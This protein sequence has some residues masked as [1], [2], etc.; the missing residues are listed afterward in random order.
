M[1]IFKN[2]LNLLRL[3]S[4]VGLLFISCGVLGDYSSFLPDLGDSDRSVISP[5]E[6]D[7]LGQKIIQDIYAQGEIL[8]DYD[9]NAYL[10]DL[11]GEIVSYSPMAGASFRF[12]IIKDKKIN[13]FALPG[14]YICIF[15]GLIYTTRTEAE[16]VSVISH[17]ISHIVLHHIF[18]GITVYNR[19]QWVAIAGILAGGLLA[20]INPA[21]AMIAINGVS[22]MAIENILSFS[23]DF[24]READRLGQK[25]M[26]KAG[27]DSRAMPVFFQRMQEQNKFNDNEAYAFLRS[28][29]VTSERI[30]E[31]QI[32]ANQLQTKMRPD[33][34]RFLLIREK[35][36]VRQIG[37]LAAIEFYKQAI[38]TKKYV[39]LEAQLYGLAFAYYSNKKIEE[40]TITLNKITNPEFKNNPIVLSLKAQ[41]AVA[42]KNYILAEKLYKEALINFPEYKTLWLGEIDLYFAS[43]QLTKVSQKLQE[44]SELYPND[45]DIWGREELL[46]SDA[47]LDNEKKYHYALGNQLYLIGNYKMALEQ[48]IIALNGS[49]DNFSK[50]QNKKSDYILNDIISSKILDTKEKINFQEK[51]GSK[52]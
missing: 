44:L 29:P 13:A 1:K 12:Y 32:R 9:T 35:C 6:A 46:Y 34:T 41:L 22:G 5:V 52:D 7:F 51:Y 16:L 23:R 36:R 3:L 18:R 38:K 8:D 24:E 15:N 39:S 20:F 17:E 30:S 28:H 14:G 47:Y 21:A 26:F 27:F 43:R 25:L 45:V 49:L 48:Y 2:Y 31:A 37:L 33:S 10:N 19:S 11:G 50:T 42:S 40:A 4:I